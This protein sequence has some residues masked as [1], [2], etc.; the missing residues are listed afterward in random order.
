M[1][2]KENDK[3]QDAAVSEVM[4]YIVMFGVVIISI[5]AIYVMGYPILQSNMDSSIFESSE[6]NFI[7]LQSNM[8]M[9]AYDHVPVKNMKMKLYSSSLA[10]TNELQISIQY[11]NTVVYSNSSLSGIEYNKDDNMILYEN[12]AVFKGYHPRGAV[13]VSEPR[14]YSSTMDGVNIT[15]IGLI[16]VNGNSGISGKGIAT[17]NMQHNTSSLIKTDDTVNVTLSMNSRFAPLWKEYFED[18]GFTTGS[19]N[20]T[21]FTSYRNDTMLI[22]GQHIID[23]EI[24]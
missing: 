17:L 8:K 5:S 1:I 16:M 11:D 23:V 9:V 10:T 20:D 4:G 21:T 12:G 19:Y 15:T 6:Q 7:V 3:R 14:I 18:I 24:K 2:R 13:M 22:I